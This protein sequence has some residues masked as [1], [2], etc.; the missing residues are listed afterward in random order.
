MNRVVRGAIAVGAHRFDELRDLEPRRWSV[1]AAA[2]HDIRAAQHPWMLDETTHGYPMELTDE[3]RRE[4]RQPGNVFSHQRQRALDLSVGILARENLRPARRFVV[5]TPSP[6]QVSV[7]ALRERRVRQPTWWSV[8][9]R[10]L[11]T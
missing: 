11:R 6:H 1:L 7:S 4:R 5:A 9:G 10:A 2:D 8:R 3:R